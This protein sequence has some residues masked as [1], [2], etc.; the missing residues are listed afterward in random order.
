MLHTHS[1]DDALCDALYELRV[2]VALGQ[3]P[4]G[5][6]IAPDLHARTGRVSHRVP[7]QVRPDKTLASWHSH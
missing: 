1:L 7:S 6:L 3:H 5:L 4:P 2:P